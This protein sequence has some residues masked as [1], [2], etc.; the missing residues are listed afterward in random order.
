MKKFS[1]I[2]ST[3][4]VILLSIA[5]IAFVIFSL[6]ANLIASRQYIDGR[7]INEDL[8]TNIAEK[9]ARKLEKDIELMTQE[10]RVLSSIIENSPI[11]EADTYDGFI[12]EN[13]KNKPLVFGMGYWFEPYYYSP[14]LKYF[15]PYFYKDDN[16]QIIKTMAYSNEDYDYFKHEWYKLNMDSSDELTFTEPYYDELL[17]T[18]FLTAVVKINR[19]NDVIGVVSID[20]TLRE[21][22]NYLDM[23]DS[24]NMA[25][26]YII[27]K[28]GYLMGSDHEA[29]GLTHYSIYDANDDLLVK[30]HDKA[31]KNDLPGVLVDEDD[32]FCV[33]APIGDTGMRLVMLHSTS[34]IMKD[35]DQSILITI[36]FFVIA[37]ILLLLLTNYIL[38]R[39]IEAPLRQVLLSQLKL[40]DQHDKASQIASINSKKEITDVQ[41]MIL[42]L[43]QL[44]TERQEYTAE[45]EKGYVV[46]V[47]SLSNAIE[48]KDKYTRGHCDN[49]TRFSL[50]TAKKLGIPD[51][52]LKTL[53]YA[54]L[55]HDVGKIGIPSN[56]LN[57]PSKLNDE[58]YELIKEHSTIGYEILKDIDFLRR[59]AEIIYQHHER[60]DG[61]GYPRGLMKSQLDILT[62]IIT[63]S[64]AYDAMTSARAYRVNP[65]NPEK[66]FKILR[67]EAGTQFDEDVVEAFIQVVKQDVADHSPDKA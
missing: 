57:K 12:Y 60:V 51:S 4:N 54:A 38:T 65:M 19:N 17:S 10:A 2:K 7:R 26:S 53:E 11:L 34:L 63:V 55:L 40:S 30:I 13:I 18:M 58:E 43:N 46:T 44:M 50:E 66:A 1:F 61:K 6:T 48:A 22:G 20:M 62:R 45:V 35:I 59:S 31:Y 41:D 39:Q 52:D 16:D 67:D 28:E 37:I 8:L 21:L 29:K 23:L 15:G 33:W 42:M 24:I 5:L 27:T 9:E 32:H 49:V 14:D 64:D 3:K 56:I 36:F 25:K 47:R